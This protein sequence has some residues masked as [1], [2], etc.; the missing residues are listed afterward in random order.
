MKTFKT[1]AA[2]ISKH[3]NTANI[4]AITFCSYRQQSVHI[5]WV[6]TTHLKSTRELNIRFQLLKQEI[7]FNYS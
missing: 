4:N 3:C 2:I 6:F 1:I 7:H 5:E